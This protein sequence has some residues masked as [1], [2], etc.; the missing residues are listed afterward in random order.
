MPEQEPQVGQAFCS[1]ASTSSSVYL[2]SAAITM[3]ST[4]SSACSLPL[5][6]ALPAS[7]GPP[8]TKT[9]GM[10]RRMAASSLPGATLAQLEMQTMAAAQWPLTMY[11]TASAMISLDGSE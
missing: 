10:L 7:S 1:T 11:S 4:R 3:A 5:T 2:S 8:E 9:A 6:S